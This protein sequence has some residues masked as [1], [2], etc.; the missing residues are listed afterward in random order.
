MGFRYID[1]VRLIVLASSQSTTDIQKAE[2]QIKA[3]INN[4]TKSLILEPEPN[5]NNGFRFIESYITFNDRSLK[6]AYYSKNFHHG[7]IFPKELDTYPFQTYTAQSDWGSI[8][9]T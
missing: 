4:L 6:I 7:T 3:F 5:I 1:D 8:S 9:T 2:I